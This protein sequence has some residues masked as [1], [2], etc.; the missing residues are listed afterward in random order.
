VTIL[1]KMGHRVKVV[2]DGQIALIH[3][4]HSDYDLVL[5]DVQ[6]PAM[7]G[8]E[9]TRIIR[10][11][12]STIRNHAIPI[13]ALTAAARKDDEVRCLQAGMNAYISKPFDIVTF[14][15]VM[16]KTMAD[17]GAPAE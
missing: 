14:Q 17:Q 8:L 7:G 4:E 9:A 2:G 13:I 1:E 12:R 11:P 5:M 16:A 10:N 15:A 3:L 6:M